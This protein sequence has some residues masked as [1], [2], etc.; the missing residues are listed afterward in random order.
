MTVFQTRSNIFVSSDDDGGS[1]GRR[2]K[3]NV[4]S[5][6]RIGLCN[7]QCNKSQP[8]AFHFLLP[9]RTTTNQLVF[10]FFFFVSLFESLQNRED[11]VVVVV[12]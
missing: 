11:V 8:P 2:A 12:E 9:T 3:L 10:L 5:K 7:V 6:G 1:D 4:R